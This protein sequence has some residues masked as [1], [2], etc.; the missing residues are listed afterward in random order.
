MRKRT[1]LTLAAL[2]LVLAVGVWTLLPQPGADAQGPEEEETK[3]VELIDLQDAGPA[4]DAVWEEPAPPEEQTP[5][6]SDDDV[7]IASHATSFSYQG[8]LIDNGQPANGAYDLRFVMY[9][10]QVGGTQIGFSLFREDVTISEGLFSVELDFGSSV[11]TGAA[12]YLEVAVRPGDSTD[13]HTILSPRRPVTPTPYA[14][15]AYDADLLD[16]LDSTG[17]ASS[18]HTHDSRYYRKLS[19]TQFTASVDAG[20]TVAYF[21]FGWPT[22]EIMY[23]SM[24]PTTTDGRVDWTVD[25]R[26]TSNNTFTYYITIRNTGSVDTSFAARYIRFR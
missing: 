10:A 14:V 24:H 1:W 21:T 20:E 15:Y 2:L 18:S 22:D 7:G 16:G 23:W 25:I 5:E 19:G 8:R 17:F 12:R 13:A 11:F 4:P 26:L 6:A 9:D 3:E